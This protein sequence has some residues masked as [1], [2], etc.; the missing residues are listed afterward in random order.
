MVCLNNKRGKSNQALGDVFY[1]GWLIVSLNA[2]DTNPKVLKTCIWESLIY[3][4]DGV[5]VLHSDSV[6]AESPLKN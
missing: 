5:Q 1:I 2:C 4:A 3:H 6:T